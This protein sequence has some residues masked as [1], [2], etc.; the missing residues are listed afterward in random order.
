MRQEVRGKG[1]DK[2]PPQGCRSLDAAS[3]EK[4][5]KKAVKQ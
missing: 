1:E 5:H 2:L 4:N 3:V